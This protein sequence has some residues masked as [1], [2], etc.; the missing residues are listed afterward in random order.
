MVAITTNDYISFRFDG[1]AGTAATFWRV[2]LIGARFLKRSVRVLFQNV[3][4]F[5]VHRRRSR[6]NVTTFQVN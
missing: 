4:T 5:R 6:Q 1:L 3:K 2:F